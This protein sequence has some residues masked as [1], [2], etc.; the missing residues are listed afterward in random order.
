MLTHIER[1]LIIFLSVVYDGKGSMYEIKHIDVDPPRLLIKHDQGD[2][3]ILTS[4]NSFPF[5]V[6]TIYFSFCVL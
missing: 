6:F 4:I 2:E 5:T 3:K 1:L